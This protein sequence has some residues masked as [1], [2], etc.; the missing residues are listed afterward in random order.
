MLAEV[1][2]HRTLTWWNH[3]ARGTQA[4]EELQEILTRIY[5][6]GLTASRLHVQL[7]LPHQCGNVADQ[8][9]QRIYESLATFDD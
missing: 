8:A 4:F 7:Q 5:K 1:D 3:S 2:V 6:L 9:G